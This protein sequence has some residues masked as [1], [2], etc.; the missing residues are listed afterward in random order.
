R[1]FRLD[2]HCRR[3][4]EGAPRLCMPPVEPELMREAVLAV[5]RQDADWVPS[6]PGT[7]MYIRPTLVAT[8]AFLG[9]R[10]AEQYLFYIILT[11]VGGR[12]LLGRGHE[13]GEDLRREELR[14]RG[15]RRPRRGQGGRQLRRQPA[16]R[17]DGAPRGLRPGP[18]ARRQGAPLPRGSRHHEP[19]AEDQG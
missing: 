8:E 15:G 7:A 2:R 1:V 17:R 14:A 6:S 5:V 4:A 19:V 12:G 10:P 3:L 9:V 11:P 16:R 18:V 13:A